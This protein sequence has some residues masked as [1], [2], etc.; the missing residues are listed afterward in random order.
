MGN[1]YESDQILNEPMENGQIRAR[2]WSLFKANFWRVGIVVA[3]AMSVSSLIEYALMS[4]TSNADVILWA[5]FLCSLL[6]MPITGIGLT[7]FIDDVWRGG[8]PKAGRLFAFCRT[9]ALYAKAIAIAVVSTAA[10]VGVSLISVLMQLGFAILTSSI[11]GWVLLFM[12]LFGLVVIYVSLRLSMVTLAFIRDRRHRV[13][14]AYQTS[15]RATKGSVAR[16]IAMGMAVMLPPVLFAIAV[17]ALS[18]V[19]A[20]SPILGSVWWDLLVKFLP[21]LVYGGYMS[22]ADVGLRSELLALMGEG[23]PDDMRTGVKPRQIA[24]THE[25]EDHHEQ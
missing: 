15:W 3:V 18:F 20:L 24:G 21:M 10:I 8:A 6:V 1:R 4:W 5:D 17:G 13:F 12:V 25:S 23:A 7:V 16:I 2:A 11:G 22:L 9:P 14:R 19:D